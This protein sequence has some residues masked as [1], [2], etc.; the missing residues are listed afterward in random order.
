[1]E[2]EGW[3]I[4][5]ITHLY[6]RYPKTSRMMKPPTRNPA[7]AITEAPWNSML[8]ML[9]LSLLIAD[10]PLHMSAVCRQQLISCSPWVVLLWVVPLAGRVGWGEER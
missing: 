10:P 2:D 9:Y 1:M 5:R 7:V 3:K 6:S 8:T 4:G